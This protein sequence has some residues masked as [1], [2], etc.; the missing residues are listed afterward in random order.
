MSQFQMIVMTKYI[1]DHKQ[2]EIE[3]F[4]G[5]GSNQEVRPINT[6]KCNDIKAISITRNQSRVQSNSLQ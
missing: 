3:V 2:V 5:S 4:M 1:G 6:N